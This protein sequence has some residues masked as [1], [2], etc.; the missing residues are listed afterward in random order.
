GFDAKP[1]SNKSKDDI[2]DL[3]HYN[4]YSLNKL[5]V[6]IR[7]QSKLDHEPSVNCICINCGF[8][9]LS[10]SSQRYHQEHCFRDNNTKKRN[11]LNSTDSQM[12]SSSINFANYQAPST[13]AAASEFDNNSSSMEVSDSDSDENKVESLPEEEEQTFEGFT[14]KSI[15]FVETKHGLWPALI[16]KISPSERK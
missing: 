8:E 11:S 4:D 2:R 14:E 3:S 13:S 5:R 9:S 10:V 6:H 15:V 12:N 16:T 7:L 1:P